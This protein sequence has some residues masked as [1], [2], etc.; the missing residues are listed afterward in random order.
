MLLGTR[1]QILALKFALHSLPKP[2]SSKTFA[3]EATLVRRQK[4]FIDH[5]LMFALSRH[6]AAQNYYGN[7]RKRCEISSNIDQNDFNNFVLVFLLLTLNIFHTFFSVCIV[8][9]EHVFV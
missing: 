2:S 9:F 8:D 4:C 1:V 5:F 7:T 3:D 6:V